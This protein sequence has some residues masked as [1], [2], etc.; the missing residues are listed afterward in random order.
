MGSV[1]V[2]DVALDPSGAAAAV[3]AQQRQVAGA[4]LGNQHVAVGQN[5][6]APRIDQTRHKRSRGEAGRHLRD[7]S[8][9]SHYQRPIGDDRPDLRRRQIGRVDVETAAD[10]LL[11][12][13]VL[14]RIIRQAWHLPRRLAL[15]RARGRAHETS[16][17]Q[18]AKGD[19]GA[20]A[21]CHDGSV[22]LHRFV[23]DWHG[24]HRIGSPGAAGAGL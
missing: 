7:L 14:R 24:H 13:E 19:Q 6:Q 11:H 2:L 4:L 10:L 23:R 1:E 8:A 9:I 16:G 5:E 20:R 15:L 3:V 18:N 22:R 17:N 12:H 21:L